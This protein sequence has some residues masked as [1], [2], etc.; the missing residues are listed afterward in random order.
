[1][2]ATS[3]NIHGQK[4]LCDLSVEMLLLNQERDALIVIALELSRSIDNTLSSGWIAGPK[5]K[6]ELNKKSKHATSTLE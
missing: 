2:T 4:P 6:I 1:M 3:I 5:C